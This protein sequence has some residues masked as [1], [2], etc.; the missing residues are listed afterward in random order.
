MK[1][2][3]RQFAAIL[4][5][6]AISFCL[7]GCDALDAM[8]EAH[9][10]YTSMEPPYA[11]SYKGAT[12]RAL[13]C[14]QIADKGIAW[15]EWRV[16]VTKPDVPVLLS[17][18]VGTRFGIDAEEKFLTNY[19]DI[20]YVRE[21][22]YDAAEAELKM[23]DPYTKV[24]LRWVDEEHRAHVYDLTEEEKKILRDILA[25]EPQTESG[26]YYVE[27]SRTVIYQSETGLFYQ[28][29]HSIIKNKEGYFIRAYD[30]EDW[31]GVCFYPAKGEAAEQLAELMKKYPQ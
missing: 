12:Y 24:S 6:L 22:I 31:G 2:M 21:D 1:K 11:I 17:Q 13:S 28:E 27:D 15:A 8:R 16:F 25:G 7:V 20:V 10:V 14:P 5:L 3:F 9:A 26:E 18:Q 29:E 19:G 23:E 4:A 30:Y